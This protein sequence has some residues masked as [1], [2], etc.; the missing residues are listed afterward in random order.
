M[1]R[2]CHTAGLSEEQTNQVFDHTLA[3]ASQ[4]NYRIITAPQFAEKIY[5]VFTEISGVQDPYL[6]LRKEQND[7]VLKKID[8]FSERIKD[9][10]DPLYSSAIYSLLGNVIDYGGVRLFDPNQLFRSFDEDQLTLNDYSW[11]SEK[12]AAADTLLFLGDNA[13]EA[14]FDKLFIQEMKRVNRDVE[15]FYGVRSAPAI[16]DVLLGDAHYIGINRLTQVIETGS[17]LAGTVISLCNQDFQDIYHRADMIVSK[18]QGNFETLENE[19]EDILFL[20]KVKCEIVAQHV[21]LPIGSLLFALS[22]TIK[23]SDKG[24]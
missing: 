7:L 22:R 17:T 5:R 19:R 9:A 6:E 13:G 1:I 15:I 18:G 10:E 11:F 21:G 14:V 3:A 2:T 4:V 16:N 20:F 8:F 12:L 23:G 24:L